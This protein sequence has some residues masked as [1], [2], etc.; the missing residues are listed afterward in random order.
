MSS[1]GE[2]LLDQ[3]IEHKGAAVLAEIDR[4]ILALATAQVSFARAK[5]ELGILLQ[6]VRAKDYWKDEY[7]SYDQYIMS[8]S[9]MFDLQRTQLYAYAGLARDLL[10][11]IGAEKLAEMGFEK[12][13]MLGKVKQLTGS[14]PSIEI[15][16]MAAD[17]KVKKDDFRQILIASKKLPDLPALKNR[18]IDYA[19]DD[20]REA[21]IQA[22]FV[23]VIRTENLS[24][25][26]EV[27]TGIVL[28]CLAAE[29]LGSHSEVL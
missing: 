8:R 3:R 18:H 28:E 19:A 26:E 20:D 4:R 27:R 10:P 14:L 12:A 24:G 7:G 6:E 23:S 25:T 17:R 16:D 9:R 5:V 11:E 1:P 29:Y 13:K 2:Y 21:T 22:A 15:M